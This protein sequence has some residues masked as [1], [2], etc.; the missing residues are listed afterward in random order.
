MKTK[1]CRGVLRG[2]KEWQYKPERF[3]EYQTVTGSTKEC[4]RECKGVPRSASEWSNIQK[5]KKCRGIL[6]L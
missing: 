2:T 4:A 5:T 1:K 3:E 6:L